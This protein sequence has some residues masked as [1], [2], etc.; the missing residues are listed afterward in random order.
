MIASVIDKAGLRNRYANPDN[1]YEIA[2]RFCLE[3][4]FSF[5]RGIGQGD[6]KTTVIVECRGKREDDELELA[7]LRIV[8][9]DNRWGRIP[10]ELGFADKKANLIGLQIAD[11]VSHPVGR[12]HLKPDQPNRAYDSIVAKFRHSPT[13][14]IKGWGLKTFP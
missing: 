5:L 12:H 8:A 1:P 9:G 14:E 10:F 11:L 3:R 2:L 7:F 4:S 13:G 6:R